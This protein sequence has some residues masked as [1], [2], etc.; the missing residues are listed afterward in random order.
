VPAVAFSLDTNDNHLGS[1][2]YTPAAGIARQV[3]ETVIKEG[4]A[5]G[6]LL[7]VNIPNRPLDEIR[8][9]RI[10]RQGLRVYRDRL[11]RRTDPRGKPYYWI[12]GDSPTGIPE[13][14][15]DI[16][17]LEDGYVSI[18]PLQ[19]DLTAY[20]AMERMKPWELLQPVKS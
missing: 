9:Y 10:T 16:G 20:P 13:H 18:T 3:V 6:T 17:A 4:L 11:D 19:L 8:G 1:L 12:G 15:T 2:D 5:G 7:N 14:D